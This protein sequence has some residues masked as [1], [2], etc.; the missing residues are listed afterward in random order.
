M[1]RKLSKVLIGLSTPVIF[2]G[3]ALILSPF[4][5]Y[6]IWANAMLTGSASFISIETEEADTIID[7]LEIYGGNMIWGFVCALSGFT[8]F[9]K[10]M[11]YH[12]EYTDEKRYLKMQLLHAHTANILDEHVL[13]HMTVR[14]LTYLLNKQMINDGGMPMCHSCHQR[15]TVILT[16]NTSAPAHV[17]TI[18]SLAITRLATGCCYGWQQ[19]PYSCS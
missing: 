6:L 3:L 16:K 18:E 4:I 17:V 7:F 2:L 1:E 11:N 13:A 10:G 9:R 15:I 5:L 8:V 12:R 14:R 19:L